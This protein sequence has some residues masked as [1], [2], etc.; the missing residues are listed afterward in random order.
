MSISIEKCAASI[1][2]MDLV[3]KSLRKYGTEFLIPNKSGSTCC[4]AYFC[5]EKNCPHHNEDFFITSKYPYELP[6]YNNKITDEEKADIVETSKN[7]FNFYGLRYNVEKL[8]YTE[9]I[10]GKLVRYM[11]DDN[12]TFY[13]REYDRIVCTTAFR[14]L[15]YKTQVMVNS[16]SDDQR[17]RL[18]HSIEVQKTAKKI[19][20]GIQANWE[21]AETISI[22]HDIGHTPFGHVGETAIKKFLEQKDS[23][24]F[25]HAVQS[26][27]VL[28]E[29]TGHPILSNYGM[30]GLGLSDYVLEGVLKHDSD[31]FT[32]GMKNSEF[33]QQYDT[34]RLCD[35]VGM[36]KVNY[37]DEL[38]DYLKKNNF[39]NSELE[40]PQ[41]LIGSIE[42]Q[43]V[44]W[45][46]KIAYLGHD[47]EEFIDTGLLEKLMSRVNDMILI[48]ENI[49][50]MYCDT[51]RK[52]AETVQIINIWK[53]LREINDDY[54]RF[55]NA[56]P[57]YSAE[58]WN[59]VRKEMEEIICAINLIE[60]NCIEVKTKDVGGNSE[61]YRC[62]KYF[63]A[64]E[65]AALKNYLVMTISWVE[66][67][68]VYPRTYGLKNDPIYIFYMYLTRVRSIVITPKVTDTIIKRT[69]EYIK[70]I[71]KDGKM[72]RDDYLLECNKKWAYKYAYINRMKLDSS[73]ARKYL[74]KSIRT[75]FLVGFH[76]KLENDDDTYI[77]T[78]G[79]ENPP[80][81][82]IKNNTGYEFDQ[83]Y[84]CML[85]IFD[86]IGEEFINS[87]RV[88]FMK[89]T[90]QEIIST[91]LEYY[92]KH[93]DMLPYTYRNR[94]N[95]QQ[96]NLSIEDNKPE[97]TDEKYSRHADR[98]KARAVADYVAYMTDRMA[99]LKYDEIKSSDSKW[100]N[101]YSTN[102]T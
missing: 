92:Y 54:I 26:V 48:I 59:K 77:V 8:G 43:I 83:K 19:A 76:D 28:D 11:W 74:K 65:Y 45:A 86:F 40:L 3:N 63:S 55:D 78:L 87:T 35:I 10:I 91:L 38:R 56:N 67:L 15:Q 47:W 20:I 90:A 24:V 73:K 101:N 99:K 50:N 5:N 94:Y 58:I 41:V 81:G 21:L 72:D 32:D 30:P 16:A 70:K 60:K 100:S 88:K 97:I 33:E 1:H 57:T 34:S 51:D 49:Y 13:N 53:S 64:R 42:S 85:Y 31:T 89:H 102:L 2:Q 95:T 82:Y 12:R 37:K 62:H 61:T 22:A 25:S 39:V 18:M 17:T 27:K 36:K 93:P 29:L 84:N 23:G 52:D 75:C 66:L 80:A 44:A 7:I 4:Y 68:D 14:H 6:I 98:C 9:D 46:D 69:N 79:G 96:Y 71:D